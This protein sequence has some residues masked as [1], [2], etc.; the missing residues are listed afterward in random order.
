MA[1][2]R[3]M[4][5]A[6]AID[7]EKI[8]E[9]ISAHT[10][11]VNALKDERDQYKT[12]AEKLPGVQKELNDLKQATTDA[13]GKD[14]WKV[15]YD[16]LKEDFDTFKN[17][18]TAKETKAKKAD[19]YK[20]LLKECG[21]ADK[22]IAAVTRVADLDAIKLD[23][24]GKIADAEELKKSI[25]DEWSDFIVSTT[26]Q[27]ANTPKPQGGTGASTMTKAEIMAIKDTAERQKAIAQNLNLFGA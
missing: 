26:T 1:L 11:T 4:L 24:N 21:I 5:K 13:D 27:G 15:K 8:D 16:A 17:E 12:D 10:D 20:A 7:D 6:M 22:R 25:R 2:T 18:I 14:R 19:A 9:I 3:K 23:E